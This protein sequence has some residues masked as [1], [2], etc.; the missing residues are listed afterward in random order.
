MRLTPEEFEAEKKYQGLMYFVKMML[1]DG[2][3]SDCEY[4]QIAADYAARFSPRTGPLLAKINL[5]CVP[6]RVMNGGGKEAGNLE[7]SKD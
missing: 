4:E 2:L 1:R 5:Q 7:N 6:K 3:I